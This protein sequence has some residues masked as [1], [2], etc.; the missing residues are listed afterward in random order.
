MTIVC[1]YRNRDGAVWLGADSRTTGSRFIFP[2]MVDKIIRIGRWAIGHSGNETALALLQRKGGAISETDDPYEV[3]DI[4]QSLYKEADYKRRTDDDGAPD[5]SQA[6][7][8]ATRSEIWAVSPDGSVWRPAWGFAAVGSGQ[9]YAYG[10]AFVL[11]K[12]NMGGEALVRMA[13][14]AACEFD[15][16]CGGEVRVIRVE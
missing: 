9:D 8:L 11:H 1:G 7:I 15:T 3:V 6:A 5:Y 10:A 12:G 14:Y 13:I 4:M 16:G 2:E